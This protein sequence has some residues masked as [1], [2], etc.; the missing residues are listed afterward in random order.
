MAQKKGDGS[1]THSLNRRS[2]LFQRLLSLM[3]IIWPMRQC[4]RIAGGMKV[5]PEH[6]IAGGRHGQ[7]YRHIWQNK[8]AHGDP[9]QYLRL[10]GHKEEPKGYGKHDL[11]HRIP[12][13]ICIE[14]RPEIVQNAKRLGDWEA[15]TIIG[16]HHRCGVGRY[17]HKAR[18][19]RGQLSS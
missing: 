15:D 8:A 19:N 5:D 2:L 1:I 12:K 17:C 13:R 4:R 10:T 3:T 11:R 7:I 16:Q 6:E 14:Q 18:K 9:Y